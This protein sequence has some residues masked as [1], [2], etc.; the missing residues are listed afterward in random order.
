MTAFLPFVEVIDSDD[1][2]RNAAGHPAALLPVAAGAS[3]DAPSWL[4]EAIVELDCPIGRQDVEQIAD[5]EMARSHLTK[6]QLALVETHLQIALSCFVQ[7]DEPPIFSQEVHFSHAT[8]GNRIWCT[9]GGSAATESAA[10]V[11]SCRASRGASRTRSRST[12]WPISARSEL[13]QTGGDPSRGMSS[14]SPPRSADSWATMP[15][16][17]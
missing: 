8:P 1:P 5:A 15:G 11:S 14:N 7:E 4:P 13:P 3:A 2:K 9:T 16:T 12:S 10:G 6:S 17:V